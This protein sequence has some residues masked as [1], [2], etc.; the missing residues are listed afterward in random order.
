MIIVD[1][2]IHTPHEKG[3]IEMPHTLTEYIVVLKDGAE[4]TVYAYT[5]EG[6]MEEA[7]VFGYKPSHAELA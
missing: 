1:Q 6:A 4:I 3:E 2:E 7:R 5:H